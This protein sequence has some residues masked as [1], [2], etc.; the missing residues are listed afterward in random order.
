MKSATLL[1]QPSAND[2]T[3]G[4]FE[5]DDGLLELVSLELPWRDLD[6]NGIGDPQRSCINAGLYR[7]VWEESP[8]MGWTY[9]VQDVPGRSE[10][11]IHVGNF[12]GEVEDGWVSDV[13]GCILLGKSKGVLTPD[14]QKHPSAAPQRAVLHSHE[15][16]DALVAWGAREPFML[17]IIEPG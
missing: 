14:Q 6:G 1:R 4:S 5:S 17:H 3:L 16:I 12:A 2:G 10:I 8:R 11:L 7:C 9:H 13:L 15:A